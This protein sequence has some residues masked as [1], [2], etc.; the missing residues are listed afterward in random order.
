MYVSKKVMDALDEAME[1]L[2]SYARLGN[3]QAGRSIDILGDFRRKVRAEEH[4][5]KKRQKSKTNDY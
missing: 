5:R 2:E 4:K 3:E 1:A